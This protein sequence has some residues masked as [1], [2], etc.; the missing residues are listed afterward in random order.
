M[1]QRLGVGF[2]NKKRLLRIN[3]VQQGRSQEFATGGDK[4]GGLGDGSP[5]A[6]SRGRAPVGAWGEA[7]R[8][9]KHVLN[10]RLNKIH[11]NSTQ[12]K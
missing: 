4:R 5:S 1:V 2:A 8:S 3:P 9:R 12:Q 7:L 10:I 6:G 11:K